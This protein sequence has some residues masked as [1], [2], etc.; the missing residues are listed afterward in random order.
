MVYTHMAD[1]RR[2]VLLYVSS[3]ACTV[4]YILRQ[5]QL[6]SCSGGVTTDDG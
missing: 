4:I 1:I 2:I 6:R 3:S 5:Y